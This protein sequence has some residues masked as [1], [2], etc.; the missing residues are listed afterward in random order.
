MEWPFTRRL[1]EVIRG[2]FTLST[3]SRYALRI[4][5]YLTRTAGQGP[6][7][8]QIIADHEGIPADYVAQLLVRLKAAGF[9]TSTRGAGGGFEL[10][11]SPESTKAFDVLLAMEGPVRIANCQDSGANCGRKG[12]CPTAEVWEATA[13]A[14]EETL[15]RFTL[16]ELAEK[17]RR[18][19]SGGLSYEI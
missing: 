11:A 8:K 5:I 7:T 4:L 12:R 13:K 10:A 18:S 16:A 1:E 6:L 9:V 17:A 15:S 14:I 3:R 19:E 2:M